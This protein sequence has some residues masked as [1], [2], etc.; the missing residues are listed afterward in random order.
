[1]KRRIIDLYLDHPFVFWPLA[2]AAAIVVLTPL[3]L[4]FRFVS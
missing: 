2:T 1:M 4:L 3:L